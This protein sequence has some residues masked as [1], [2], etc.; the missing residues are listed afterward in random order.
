MESTEKIRSPYA[1]L[2]LHRPLF[3]SR[4]PQRYPIVLALPVFFLLL[5]CPC[6]GQE[7]S[8]PRSPAIDLLQH[9]VSSGQ[10]T[11][12]DE[13]WARLSIQHS[14]IVE[15]DPTDSNLSLVTFVWKGARDTNN[16]VVISP[17]TLVD[18]DGAIMQRVGD[19]DVWF[20]TYRMR[21]DASMTY[22]F[23][24]NDTLVPFEKEKNL[25]SRMKSWEADPLNPL[26]FQVGG[27]MV[28]S[29]LELPEAPSDKWTRELDPSA[30]GK[31]VEQQFQSEL[32]QNHRPAWIYTP[33][34][35]DPGKTYP[36]LVILDGES[37]TSLIPMPTIL[38]NLI[39][40]KAIPPVVAVLLG[41]GPGDARDREMNCSRAWSDAL[42][43]EV[44]PWLRLQ[45]LRF[46]DNIT[47]IGDSLTG[48]A[49]SCAA[50][51]YPGTF[52]KVVSQSGSYFRAPSGEEPEWLARHLAKEPAIP[53]KFYLEVGLLETA[54]IPSRDP[55]ML[56]ANRHLRDVL[57]AKGNEV[58]YVEH[59]S[60]HEHVSWRAT[61]AEALI[62]L[63][64][65]H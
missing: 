65:A 33:T 45:H 19:T 31:L 30:K 15:A 37:Y 59:F 13:F 42:V 36:L 40:A 4:P 44:L 18:F 41:N 10:K 62:A 47:I 54:A 39:A 25:F 24:I 8:V 43:N 5:I 28:A 26:S 12:V 20:K 9:R 2:P 22:R 50:R 51:D 38:D 21:N 29:V 7:I 27:G 53:V 23:A 48:L 16:V 32:L 60:G 52:R 56:T 58:H 14:P 34:H 46:A 63:L 1:G 3:S 55:S 11:A 61:I 17:L 6:V 35:F 64:S 57:R 49:A